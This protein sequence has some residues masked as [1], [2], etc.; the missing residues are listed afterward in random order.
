MYLT[1]EQLDYFT[2]VTF[3]RGVMAE[4]MGLIGDYNGLLSTFET[5]QMKQHL[6]FLEQLEGYFISMT[7][8]D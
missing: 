8:Q 2:R 4:R 7:G 3:L 1:Q 6:L 5:W